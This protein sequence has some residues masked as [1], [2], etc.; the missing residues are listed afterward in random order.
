MGIKVGLQLCG[1]SIHQKCVGEKD[2]EK[3][4]YNREKVMERW[5]SMLHICNLTI[6]ST[7][8]LHGPTVF[9]YEEG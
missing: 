3:S 1:K 7:Y 4:G 5:K 6:C 9:M 2:T 8:N